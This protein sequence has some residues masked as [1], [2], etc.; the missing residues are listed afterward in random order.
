MV[1]TAE[2]KRREAELQKTLKEPLEEQ[3]IYNAAVLPDLRPFPTPALASV[4]QETS[5][6]GR[7][8]Q[9]PPLQTHAL[10]IEEYQ[11]IYHSVVGSV[12]RTPSGQTRPCSLKLGRRIK[13]R[14]WEALCCPSL[15]VE[16]LPERR[17]HITESFSRA[18]LKSFAP[19]F[20]LDTTGE[21]T[22]EPP[23]KKRRH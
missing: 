15:R 5:N 4:P 14:L 12:L 13:Q 22:P 17:L 19:R 2:R 8:I 9:V 6:S 11:S 7:L 1:Q 23:K 3:Y 20:D 10:K 18:T 16:V 21:P